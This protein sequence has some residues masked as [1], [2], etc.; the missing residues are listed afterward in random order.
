MEELQDLLLPMCHKQVLRVMQ[1]SQIPS[2]GE[3]TA[4]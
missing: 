2:S 1:V 3:K 4:L